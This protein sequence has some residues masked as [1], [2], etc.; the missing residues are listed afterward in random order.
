MKVLFIANSTS[1]HTARWIS[2]LKDQSWDLHLFPIE[3][4]Y[5]HLDICNIHVHKV[6]KDQK[7]DSKRRIK[8]TGV[9]WP[10]Y[11]GKEKLRLLSKYLSTDPLSLAS[12]L[13]RVI[14]K[15][16]PDVVHSV[17]YLG[18]ILTFE[19]YSRLKNEKP[20]WL[21][22]CWGSELSYFGHQDELES[23]I[24][25]YISSC[26][27]LIADTQRELDIAGSYGFKGRLLGVYPTAGGYNLKEMMQYRQN[28]IVSKRK[29]IALKGRHGL[30]GGRGLYGLKAIE[31]C[32]DLLHDYEIKI[33][34]PDGNIESAV[35]Y[36]RI[37][38]NLNI[39]IIPDQSTHQEILTIF[40]ESRIAIGLG[41][42]D[43]TP[44][45]MLE[46]M[47]LGALPIQ[48]NTA[49]TAG[50]IENYVNGIIVEPE[51]I[52]N[53]VSALTMALRND[54]LVDN[55]AIINYQ[56]IKNKIDSSVIYPSVVDMYQQC[57]GK[58]D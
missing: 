27:Y 23:P 16:K 7:Y 35:E 22:F 37:S 2:Q 40:G 38:T 32:K 56:I 51:N 1:I 18:G 36:V 20:P 21:H 45:S 44:N 58:L 9:W 11:R 48:S 29:T 43:G 52:D 14:S 25:K 53:I 30:Y 55:A 15:I 39:T 12:T 17:S 3:E 28:T 33:F 54:E 47:T 19:A 50:W 8:C 41:L 5:I 57:A 49:D 46:A 13:S 10:F 42:I 26:D 4:H 34:L 6:F 24:R 31:L